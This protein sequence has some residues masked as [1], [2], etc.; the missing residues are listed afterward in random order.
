MDFLYLHKDINTMHACI[1]IYFNLFAIVLIV[2]KEII[3]IDLESNRKIVPIV[4][5]KTIMARNIMFLFIFFL[6]KF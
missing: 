3:S 4:V 5:S 2:V 1:V 6:E